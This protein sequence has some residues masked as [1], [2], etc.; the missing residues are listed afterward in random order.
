MKSF[1]RTLVW[2]FFPL[3]ILYTVAPLL[4]YI[5]PHFMQH[6]FFLNFVKFPWRE[7]HNLTDHGVDAK[8]LNFYIDG[9]LMDGFRPRLGLWHIMPDGL[10]PNQAVLTKEIAE[11]ILKDDH[12]PVV[13]YLHGNSFDRT[14]R[15][16]IELYKILSKMGY[17][18]F[19]LDYRGYGDSTGRPTEAGIVA[20]SRAVFDYVKRLV[21]DRPL[22]V[23]GHSMGTGVATSL[24]AQLS[25]QDN[26]PTALVLESPFNNLRDVINNHPFSAPFRFLPWFDMLVIQPL[27]D[28]GLVMQSDHRIKQITCP[29]LVFH[30]ADDHIIP[31]KLGRKLVE[32]ARN[33]G[34]DVN[35]VEFDTS[36][37]YFHKYIHRAPEVPKIVTEFFKTSQSQNK[38][39]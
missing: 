25:Q 31:I 19:A 36:R 26:N 6:L 15:H 35:F 28:S 3:L 29:I 39:I 34:R 20:D 1:V 30:A 9:P 37:A 2:S 10:T 24:V 7:Y 4:V 21:P 23:W 33:S 22:L 17:H 8:G 11:Q 14:T 32:A 18:V 38:V 13:I 5:F 12:R 16:R 27:I